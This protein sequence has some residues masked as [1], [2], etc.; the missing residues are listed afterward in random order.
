MSGNIFGRFFVGCSF[1][2]FSDCKS[3][4]KV[5]LMYAFDFCHFSP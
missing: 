5:N 1:N 3:S 2:L 4:G